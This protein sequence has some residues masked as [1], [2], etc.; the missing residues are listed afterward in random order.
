MEALN[1]S[2]ETI[3]RILWDIGEG[4]VHDI[5][6]RLSD[7]KPPYTTV[8]SIIRVLEKKGYVLHK[9]YGRTYVYLPAISKEEYG[10]RSFTDLVGYYFNG[11]PKNVLSF[12]VEENELKENE[13][14]ELRQLIEKFN[15][16]KPAQE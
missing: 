9:A 3:M 1:H 5:I 8:S 6:A 4:V 11:S 16:N 12:L 7:P 10:K 15:Q 13:L 2:E 14:E